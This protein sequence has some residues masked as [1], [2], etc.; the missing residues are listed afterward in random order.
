MTK[1]ME[2]TI[3]ETLFEQIQQ[4]TCST[5]LSISDFVQGILDEYLRQHMIVEMERQEIEA[6][7]RQPVTPEESEIW[8]N[9]QVWSEL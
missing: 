5:G 3:N 4:A 9:E 6:Y 2:L 1:T 7:L 8:M